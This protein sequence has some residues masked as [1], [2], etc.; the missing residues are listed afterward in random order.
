M[1]ARERRRRGGG[2]EKAHIGGV[3]KRGSGGET[4]KANTAMRER[5]NKGA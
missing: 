4:G 2:A 1:G 3:K 5:F